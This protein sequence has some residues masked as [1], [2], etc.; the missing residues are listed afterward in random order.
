MFYKGKK[1]GHSDPV[2]VLDIV[3]SHDVLPHKFGDTTSNS[4]K[5]ML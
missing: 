3:L 5:Y 1:V 4:I 2:I